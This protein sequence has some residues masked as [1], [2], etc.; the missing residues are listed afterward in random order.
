MYKVVVGGR[1]SWCYTDGE[2]DQL[3][4]AERERLGHDL[5]V[6]ESPAAEGPEAAPEADTFFEQE[7]H[8]VKNVNRALEGLRRFGLDQHDLVPAVRLAGREPPVR[9]RLESGEGGRVLAT[10]RELVAEVRKLGEKGL[11]ITRFKG[12]GEMDADELWATT[13][14]PEKRILMQVQLDDALKADEMFR[15]LMGDKVEP[16]RDFIY[17]YALEVKKEDIDYHGG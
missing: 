8:E 2:V 15:T 17:K 5:V 14:D 10:L 9:L 13:L 11:S 12:L 7:L 4:A 1:E 3:R 16:R 6:E